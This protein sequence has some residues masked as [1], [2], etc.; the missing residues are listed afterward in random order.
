MCGT[1][2]KREVLSYPVTVI[3]AFGLRVFLRCLLARRE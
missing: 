3:R 1:I 2:C